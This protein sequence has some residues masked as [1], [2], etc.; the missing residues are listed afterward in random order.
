[1]GPG[2]LPHEFNFISI[3]DLLL[4]KAILYIPALTHRLLGTAYSVSV[5]TLFSVALGRFETQ[6][7]PLLSQL[8]A[9]VYII[10]WTQGSLCYELHHWATPLTFYF[11]TEPRLALHFL[12]SSRW[13]KFMI[14]L[15]QLRIIGLHH[16]AQD[17][18]LLKINMLTAFCNITATQFSVLCSS[19]L[20]LQCGWMGQQ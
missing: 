5:L 14:L 1:M 13:I 3:D 11:E 20:W 4:N 8:S 7:W 2:S 17:K 12:C 10:S 19:L 6:M 18:I 9:C 15:P 16:Q